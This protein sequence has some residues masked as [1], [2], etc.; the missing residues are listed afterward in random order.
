M[1]IGEQI[2]KN[3]GIISNGKRLPSY[4]YVQTRQ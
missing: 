1:G 4:H 2:T 3:V